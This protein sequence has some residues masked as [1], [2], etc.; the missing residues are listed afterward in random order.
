M[1]RKKTPKDLP[2]GSWEAEAAIEAEAEAAI[3]AKPEPKAAPKAAPNM[4]DVAYVTPV[5]G[6]RVKD[7]EGM[8]LLPAGGKRLRINQHWLRRAKAGDVAL[9]FEA[10]TLKSDN[11]P[12]AS[13]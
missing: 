13:E 4:G 10:A 1:T 8:A 3:E 5:D 2:E 6:K 9:S 11:S 12:G 7:P